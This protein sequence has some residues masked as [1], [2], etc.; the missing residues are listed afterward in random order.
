MEISTSLAAARSR[1]CSMPI[2]LPKLISAGAAPP[3]GGIVRMS[4]SAVQN[5]VLSE[6][7]TLASLTPTQT[8]SSLTSTQTIVGNGGQNVIDV[9]NNVHL[10]G[11]NTFTISGGP[12]DTFV[13][14]IGNGGLQ[15]D[16]GSNIVLSGVKPSQ[17]VFYFPGSASWEVQTSGN[18]NTAGTFLAPYG[19]IQINGGVHNSDF[20]S[21][22]TLSFQSNPIVKQG[23]P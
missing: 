15:L 4:M 20:I 18:A 2:P 5:A 17:V 21:G 13:F 11:G 8:F 19:G 3:S 1:A 12:S 7:S 10:S 23:C 14:N 9:T 22:T 6:A 16:G